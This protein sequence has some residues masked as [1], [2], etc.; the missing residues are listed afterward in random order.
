MQQGCLRTIS[1]A[2]FLLLQRYHRL[3]GLKVIGW[4]KQ[5]GNAYLSFYLDALPHESEFLDLPDM[6]NERLVLT[7]YQDHVGIPAWSG[8]EQIELT[9]GKR[10]RTDVVLDWL[11]QRLTLR[12]L[13]DY[14]ASE[15]DRWRQQYTVEASERYLLAWQ[16]AGLLTARMGSY[17]ATPWSFF[18][19]YASDYREQVV[20]YARRFTECHPLY[21][22]FALD[23]VGISIKAEV[24]IADCENLDAWTMFCSG[25]TPEAI[26]ETIL[27]KLKGYPRGAV[28]D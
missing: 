23:G 26:A 10:A 2:T 9:N 8:G 3:Y 7:C 21:E 25:H 22:I 4:T 12:E 6:A 14:H 13:F 16:V 20:A 18:S 28:N 19:D 15:I 11:E 17:I 5:P 1:K 24:R 27:T